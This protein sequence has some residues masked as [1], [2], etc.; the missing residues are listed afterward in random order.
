[1]LTQGRETGYTWNLVLVAQA[2]GG[3]AAA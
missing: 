1:L 2:V 3:L